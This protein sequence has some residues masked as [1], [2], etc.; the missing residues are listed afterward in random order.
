[1]HLNLQDAYLGQ[2]KKDNLLVVVYLVNGFQ[3]KGLIKGF[4]NFTVFL[5][6]EGKIQMVYKHAITT[7]NPVK[8]ISLSFLSEAFKGVPSK[9]PPKEPPKREAP[10]IPPNA[11]RPSAVREVI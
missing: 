11:P 5:E 9:N 8:S 10:V 3:L 1:M 4:D 2:L 7:I 6:N